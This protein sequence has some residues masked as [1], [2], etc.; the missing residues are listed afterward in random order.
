[1]ESVAILA[2]PC[3]S[4]V[5]LSQTHQTG[6]AG[7]TAACAS[8][9]RYAGTSPRTSQS[10]AEPTQHSGSSTESSGIRRCCAINKAARRDDATTRAGTS[11]INESKRRDFSH[12]NACLRSARQDHELLKFSDEFVI[13]KAK[14]QGRESSRDLDHLSEVQV[15]RVGP[16]CTPSNELLPCVRSARSPVAPVDQ[17]STTRT[18]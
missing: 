15:E 1:M 17:R 9:W 8:E 10:L 18:R 16:T 7:I 4:G 2:E 12:H 14:A 3:R 11:V 5:Q 13:T 6:Q